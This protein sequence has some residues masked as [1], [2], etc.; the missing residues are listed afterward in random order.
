MKDQNFPTNWLKHIN[1]GLIEMI[2]QTFQTEGGRGGLNGEG[3]GLIAK[4]GFDVGPTF[5]SRTDI[6]FPP[7]FNEFRKKFLR[8]VLSLK[9]DVILSPFGGQKANHA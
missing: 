3:W 2:L 4:S 5:S 1:K 7:V 6:F 9:N 8:L